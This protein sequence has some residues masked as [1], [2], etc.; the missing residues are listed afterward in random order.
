M[1]GSL[2]PERYRGTV[3]PAPRHNNSDSDEDQ[4]LKMKVKEDIVGFAAPLLL[5]AKALKRH[6]KLF[7][8]IWRI[9]EE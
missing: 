5:A 2:L 8:K 1:A 3:N 6:G 4:Q 9:S 7:I